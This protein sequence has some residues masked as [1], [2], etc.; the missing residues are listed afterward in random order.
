MLDSS[1]NYIW[2]IWSHFN[3]I[4]FNIYLCDLTFDTSCRHIVNKILNIHAPG[5][6]FCH[7]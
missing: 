7:R 2:I 5:D 3:F 6:F 4:F 1:I